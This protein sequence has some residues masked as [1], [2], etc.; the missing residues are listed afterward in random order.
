MM[1]QLAAKD[2]IVHVQPAG[3]AEEDERP[4]CQVEEYEGDCC[5]TQKNHMHNADEGVCAS[6]S[7]PRKCEETCIPVPNVYVAQVC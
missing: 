2:T 5:A 6:T 1:E 4:R 3:I 7:C